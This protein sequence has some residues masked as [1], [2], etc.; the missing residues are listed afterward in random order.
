MPVD[1]LS[2]FQLLSIRRYQGYFS[3]NQNQELATAIRIF[4][5]HDPSVQVEFSSLNPEPG[6]YAPHP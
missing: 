3:L 6:L 1:F 5:F 2:N 4:L